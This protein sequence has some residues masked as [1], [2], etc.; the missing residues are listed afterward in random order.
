MRMIEQSMVV[1]PRL[2]MLQK[3]AE[4]VK[5]VAFTS[6]HPVFMEADL[7]RNQQECCEAESV[8]RELIGFR[9][10]VEGPEKH[11]SYFQHLCKEANLIARPAILSSDFLL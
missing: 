3:I 10:Q 7:L 5:Q 8:R 4:K 2:S 9:L 6:L 11:V 1:Q